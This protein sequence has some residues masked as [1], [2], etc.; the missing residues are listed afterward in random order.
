MCFDYYPF[1][2]V[3]PGRKYAANSL[4]RYG[5]NGKENDNEV[6]GE[7]N[8][9]DFGARIFDTRLAKWLS[10]DP[11]QAKYAF[12]SPYSYTLNSPLQYKD[13]DGKD[14]IIVIRDIDD[15]MKAFMAH[16]AKSFEGQ[17]EFS[18]SEL[19]GNV[20]KLNI[21]LKKDGNIKSEAALRAFDYLKNIA[22]DTKI[23]VEILP[24]DMSYALDPNHGS[25]DVDDYRSGELYT[26]ALEKHQDGFG[27]DGIGTL[28][29]HYIAEEN[30]VQNVMKLLPL[31]QR[32]VRGTDYYTAHEKALQIGLKVFGFSWAKS[33]L[34]NFDA[35]K[36]KVKIQDRDILD[37]NGKYLGTL[38]M[39]HDFSGKQPKYSSQ[40]FT[41]L[42]LNIGDKWTPAT[43][44]S[45]EGI[46]EYFKTYPLQ[47]TLDEK[48][49]ETKKGVGKKT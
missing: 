45:L 29:V 31:T 43:D 9:I 38:R 48:T 39:V 25:T 24:N 34:T 23:R 11:H 5:F 40:I 27:F 15:N 49:P 33:D 7:G 37:A 36:T 14:I 30:Y 3:M 20:H 12:E 4:Y 47:K 19:E 26:K 18:I 17:V 28:F 44:E 32:T 21:T 10:M 6:K 42:D 13:V 46:S 41:R 16:L 22:E 1:G 35:N 8:Q 2:M